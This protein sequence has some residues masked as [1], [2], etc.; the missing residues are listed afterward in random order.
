MTTNIIQINETQTSV[1]IFYAGNLPFIIEDWH[2]KIIQ[3]FTE[4]IKNTK[5]EITD[6]SNSITD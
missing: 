6:N 4:N 1:R 3:S 2:K 5:N